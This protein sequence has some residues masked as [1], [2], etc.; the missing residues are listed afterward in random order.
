MCGWFR[1]DAARASRSNRSRCSGDEASEGDSS[2]SATSRR[3]VRSCAWYTSPMLPAPSGAAISNRPAMRVPGTSGTALRHPPHG[4][5]IPRQR[6]GRDERERHVAVPAVAPR[7][8]PRIAEDDPARRHLVTDRDDRVAAD[9]GVAVIGYGQHAGAAH[10][11]GQHARVYGE[12]KDERIALRE[13]G[14]Q[15]RYRSTQAVVLD[16]HVP[17]RRPVARERRLPSEPPHVI[18]PHP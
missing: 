9:E 5:E 2:F 10:G 12:R 4:P 16:R 8:P 17:A 3:S 13:T 14:A 7:P 6:G 11:A 1:P 18:G 15:M